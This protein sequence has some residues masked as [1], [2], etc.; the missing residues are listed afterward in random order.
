[1]ALEC[2]ALTC[3]SV[4]YSGVGL[5]SRS[6]AVFVRG[7]AWI[8]VELHQEGHMLYGGWIYGTRGFVRTPR[9]RDETLN[10]K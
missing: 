5:G 2:S 9:E 10:T 4:Q 1:M 3:R 7:D 8:S 6:G